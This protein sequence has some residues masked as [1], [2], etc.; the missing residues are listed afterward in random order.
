MISLKDVFENS[1]PE[2]PPSSELHALDDKALDQYSQFLNGYAHVTICATEDRIWQ[3]VAGHGV[4]WRRLPKLQFQC[5]C[6]IAA[7]GPQGVLQPDVVALT[8]QDKRS[9]PKRTDTLAENGYITKEPCQGGGSKTS[10]LKLKKFANQA[11]SSDSITRLASTTARVKDGDNMAAVIRYDQWWDIITERLLEAEGNVVLY[12]DLSQAIGA[13]GSKIGTRALNRFAWR[14]VEIG[15]IRRLGATS[16][17]VDH[18]GDPLDTR[19]RYIKLL[20]PP[21]SNDKDLFM[22]FLKKG[23]LEKADGTNAAEGLIDEEVSKSNLLLDDELMDDA[24]LD[25]AK[26]SLLDSSLSMD[27]ASSENESLKQSPPVWS[28]EL[29]ISNIIFEVVASFGPRGA[30]SQVC[31]E[32]HKLH[33]H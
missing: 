14:L 32:I 8:G 13:L 21:T 2:A 30:S 7:H 16:D 1:T 28:P 17:D 29:S 19:T 11:L 26:S 22:T 4:D 31:I 18:A 9:V 12:K 3:T 5:L 6:V 24:M 15:L 25:N 20:R 33:S 23:T 27:L 10:L